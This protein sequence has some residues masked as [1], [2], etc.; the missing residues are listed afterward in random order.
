MLKIQPNSRQ[1]PKE[2]KIVS[3]KKYNDIIYSWI[4]CASERDKNNE[5]YIPKQKLVYVKIAADLGLDRRTV[6]KY[7]QHMNEIGLLE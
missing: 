6:A 3:H 4:Q 5:R 2:E 1:V 7:I